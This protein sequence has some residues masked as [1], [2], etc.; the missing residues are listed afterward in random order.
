MKKLMLL[1]VII[2]LFACAPPRPPKV[3]WYVD[4]WQA[5]WQQYLID[6]ECCSRMADAAFP[7]N[8]GEIRMQ[9]SLTYRHKLW[10]TYYM[11]CMQKKGHR[12]YFKTEKETHYAGPTAIEYPSGSGIAGSIQQGWPAH[13]PY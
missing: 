6:K 13:V 10:S 5:T 4:P 7:I 12:V 11:D 1:S 3:T 9:P 2:F 8:R